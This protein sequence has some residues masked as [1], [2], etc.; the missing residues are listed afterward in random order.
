V[1]RREFW[2]LLGELKQ[3]GLNVVVS[4]PYMDEA[5]RCDR[6]ALIQRGRILAIDT[7]IA[8]THSFGRPLFA[9]RAPDRYRTLRALREYTHTKSV[10]PFGETL[11]YADVRDDVAS[12]TIARDVSA[13]LGERG[14]GDATVSATE[15]TIEDTF[16]ARM[17]APEGEAVEQRPRA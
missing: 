2:E 14:V 15:P 5:N 11:H 8:V 7:P 16:M 6:V 3:G 9:V 4:T 1:S 17:G 10:Y 13:Y 12:D